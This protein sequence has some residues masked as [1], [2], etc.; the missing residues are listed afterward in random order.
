HLGELQKSDRWVTPT[1]IERETAEAGKMTEY[2][3]LRDR[4]DATVD[5]QLKVARW[6]DKNGLDDEEKAHARLA[7][8]LDP[9]QE[10]AMRRLGM[11]KFH[12]QIIPKA[13]YEEAKATFHQEL[14]DS[15]EWS[16]RLWKLRHQFERDPSS[17]GKVL[18]QI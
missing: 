12:G 9:T 14:V 10:E 5:G 7:L 18:S 13:Q 15:K 6:C 3:K 16:D 17:H 2:R 8:Q 11:V 4:G 1:E